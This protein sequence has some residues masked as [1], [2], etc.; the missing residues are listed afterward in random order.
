MT[1]QEETDRFWARSSAGEEVE[2]V[3]MTEFHSYS[4]NSTKGALRRIPGNKSLV[5]ADGMAVNPEPD[6]SFRVVE[7]EE[8][9]YRTDD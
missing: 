4:S 8:V 1:A 3:E 6:G 7:T 9:F 5:T 2:I